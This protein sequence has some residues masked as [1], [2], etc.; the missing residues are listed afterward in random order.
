M[1]KNTI[2]VVYLSIGL[3]SGIGIGYLIGFMPIYEKHGDLLGDYN[4]LLGDYNTL[5]NDYN[6]LYDEYNSL[7]AQFQSILSVL[8]DPLTNP[9]IPT[10]SQV[11][12]WL[13]TDDTNNILYTD[14]WMCGDFSAML[15]VRAKAMNWRIRISIMFYSFEFESEYGEYYTYPYGTGGHA[16]NFIVCQDGSDPDSNPDIWYIEPQTDKTW[17]LNDGNNNHGSY[18]IH[19]AWY[20]TIPNTIWYNTYPNIPYWVNHYSEFA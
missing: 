1:R 19:T 5:E 13:A 10:I 17:W 20:N 2:I 14:V 11:R 3:L 8:E 15:M 12:N 9:V 16:F 4:D 18:D 7:F 6:A